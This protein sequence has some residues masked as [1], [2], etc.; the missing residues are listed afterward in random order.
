MAVAAAELG[1]AKLQLAVLLY[2]AASAAFVRL[3]A[4][5]CTAGAA[6]NPLLQHSWCAA[7]RLQETAWGV[8]PASAA[9]ALHAGW[10][11]CTGLHTG[12]P[13]A[14]SVAAMAECDRLPGLLLA[15]AAAPLTESKRVKDTMLNCSDTGARSSL[16][17]CCCFIWSLVR[18]CRPKHS[19]TCLW[20]LR[21]L[22][23]GL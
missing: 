10:C 2:L 8:L 19:A 3:A 11:C 9:G 1:L 7:S 17:N 21:V 18:G 6:G 16:R 5:C 23:Q 14:V 15:E 4:G 12:L 20:V 22:P 13:A